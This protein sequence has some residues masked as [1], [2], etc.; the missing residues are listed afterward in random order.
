MGAERTRT[1]LPPVL[2]VDDNPED[3][4]V[5]RRRLQIAGVENPLIAIDDGDEAILFLRGATTLEGRRRNFVPCV[6]FLDLRMPCFG[7]FDVL[8]W[9]REQPVLTAMRVVIVSA[10]GL[11]EDME[12]ARL[13]GAH[14]YLVKY[15]PALTLGGIV[16]RAMGMRQELRRSA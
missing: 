10:C 14:E 13:L 1:E 9:V 7:G 16:E 8:A 3:V 2:I 4:F 5:I 12:R 6:M 15:P 11:P